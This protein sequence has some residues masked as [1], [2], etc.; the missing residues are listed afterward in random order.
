MTVLEFAGTMGISN[1]RVQDIKRTLL[2]MKKVS[3]KWIHRSLTI[4]IKSTSMITSTEYSGILKRNRNTFGCRSTTVDETRTRY[5][6]LG[7][8]EQYKQ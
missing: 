2:H 6:T 8:R 7:T 5:S 3:A 1:G 4:D